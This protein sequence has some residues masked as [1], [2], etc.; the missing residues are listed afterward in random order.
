M[1]KNKRN[2]LED[3]NII[4]NNDLNDMLSHLINKN[5]F[6]E[7]KDKVS[8]KTKNPHEWV[9]IME[10]CESPYYLNLHPYPWQK[11][12]L[13][14]FYMGSE[15]N[16]HLKI[17]NS[18]DGCQNCIWNKSF[19]NLRSFSPCLKCSEYSHEDFEKNIDM[20]EEKMWASSEDIEDLKKIEKIN[21]FINEEQL[22][23]KDLIED[24]DCLE[25][26]SV[27]KQVLEKIGKNFS[28][29]LLVLG[30]RSGKMLSL[31]TPI[32]TPEGFKTMGDL[33]PGHYVFGPDGFP[34]KIIAES[35]IDYTA[36]CY[37]ITFSNGEKIKCHAEH[38]WVTSTKNQRKNQNIKQINPKIFTTKE[39]KNTL[40]SNKLKRKNKSNNIRKEYN[41]SIKITKPL[42]FGEKDLPIHPYVLGLWLKNE[43]NCDNEIPKI[44]KNIFEY[45]KKLGYQIQYYN[46]IYKIIKCPNGES[47]L[48]IL[49]ENN[50]IKNKYIP[51]IYLKSSIKDRLELLY[52]LLDTNK[53]CNFKKNSIEFRSY[54]KDIANKTYELI[55][56]LGFKAILKKS[57]NNYKITFM[58]TANI[59]NFNKKILNQY[60]KNKLNRH[61]IFITKVKRIDAIPMK[62]IQVDNKSHQYLCG[63]SLIPTHNSML[64]S[65]M[66][67]YE[68]YK[69]IEMKNPQAIFGNLN[70]GDTI[71]ILNV[72]V[73]EQQ[74]KES[75]FDKIKPM[76]MNS[77]YFKQ[78]IS[79]GTIQ[80]RSVRFLTQRDE[81]INKQLIN[82]GLPARD[83]SIYLLSGHSNSDSL[84]GKNVLVVIIDE[85]ASMVGKD[86]SKMSDEELY[87]KLKHSIWTFGQRGKIMCISNPLTKD[88]KFF[89][90]YEQ[91]FTDPRVL[92]IQLP[93]YKVN[94]TLDQKAL[95]AE[96]EAAQR[97]GQYEQY[98]MQIEAR[99]SG[100][101]ADPFIPSEFIDM[102]FEKGGHR[103]RGEVGD[104]NLLYYMHLDPANNSDN[105]ALA[106]VHIEIDPYRLDKENKPLKIVIVD[107][108]N[109]W[110]PSETGEPVNISE[111]DEYTI[112]MS[113]QFNIVSI[114]YDMWE[115]AASSQLLQRMGLPARVTPFSSSYKQ[116][117]YSTL[118]NLFFEDRI[119]FYGLDSYNTETFKENYGFVKEAADQFKF[120]GR[121]FNR[122]S[123]SVA[124]ASGHFDDIPDCIAG[125]SFIALTNQH[126][127]VTLPRMKS[128]KMSTFR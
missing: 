69:V 35:E 116:Q 4:S 111:V 96:R 20:M 25:G 102:A 56:G 79:P 121:K 119:E 32:M 36:E 58:P 78:K 24:S 22:I 103:R 123:F 10:F 107:H 18:S 110:Q 70:E 125:A 106:I 66:A 93:S 47:F 82:E 71:C 88:G 127:Y 34:T 54:N 81:E 60:N 104:P 118:R 13:K 51:D 14:L 30:R 62:C 91:S 87:T 42:Q 48:N 57:N 12:I 9:D 90:L 64:V 109:M 3:K 15:G 43:S 40:Y 126:G 120:L 46:K 16:Q 50:L 72:A 74:A 8:K 33:H 21:L 75:V 68:S 39:I 92:M 59:S 122:K 23:N 108:I 124:A 83:G 128:V 117:I 67:L 86:G 53:Y 76:I 94:P 80:N 29:L 115:S 7:N 55:C 2:I 19:E 73:S 84:V 97:A 37:E 41:H 77:P 44:N 5:I 114:T 95:D 6:E 105:Y 38:E 63:K 85:M 101:A 26:G 65:I 31:D 27:K 52:G 112:K 1:I 45:I 99:F 100:G 89:E 113:R 17:N 98:L 11:I 61:K 49:N 28:E